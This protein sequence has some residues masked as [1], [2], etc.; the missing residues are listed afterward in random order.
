M[1]RVFLDSSVVFSAALSPTGASA[2]LLMAALHG[3][4]EVVVSSLVLEKVGRNLEK[5]RPDVLPDWDLLL[6][7]L[8]PTVLDPSSAAV[9]R[10]AAYTELKDAPLV[11]AAIAAKVDYFVSLD[12]RHL[13][14]VP[15]V[16]E[17]SGLRIVRPSEL[18]AQLNG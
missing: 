6:S 5:K 11:A 7:G 16:A 17:R 8:A 13:T 1:T 12:K 4:I 14:G 10:A 2:A 18:L 15:E 3:E 9:H